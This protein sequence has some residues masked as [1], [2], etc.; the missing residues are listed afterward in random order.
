MRRALTLFASLLLLW[1]VVAQVNHAVSSVHVHVFAGG[2]FVSFA[3]LTQPRWLGL[4][5]TVLGGLLCDANTPVVFGTHALLFAAAHLMVAHMRERV[6]R[7]D[8]LG[9]T[10]VTL[11]ANGLLYLA[12]G[13]TQ[14]GQIPA[15]ITIWPRVLTDFV[16]STTF[17][18]LV[19]PWWFALQ[20]R[21]LQVARVE[22]VGLA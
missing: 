13:L 14:W 7:D 12:L 8:T 1:T 4:C 15:A 17:V 6:P 3:A 2:L 11:V 20:A 10:I 9:R 22:R 18:A 19:T 21:A 5:V 16:A